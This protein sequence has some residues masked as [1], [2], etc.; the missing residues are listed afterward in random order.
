MKATTKKHLPDHENLSTYI[1]IATDLCSE[2]FVPGRV[3]LLIVFL[4]SPDVC[5]L[6]IWYVPFFTMIIMFR[7]VTYFPYS[8]LKHFFEH[9]KKKLFVILK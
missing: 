8:Y 4:R 9:T 5:L 6:E 3:P 2:K 7:T 1:V